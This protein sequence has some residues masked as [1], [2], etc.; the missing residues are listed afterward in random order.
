[1]L[2]LHGCKQKESL[3]ARERFDF[4]HHG[5]VIKSQISVCHQTPWGFFPA[6]RMGGLAVSAPGSGIPEGPAV[7]TFLMWLVVGRGG[8]EASLGVVFISLL[9]HCAQPIT[10][11]HLHLA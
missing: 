2:A 7:L 5:S 1:M 10:A 9:A 4:G 3:T 6:W 8:L 11:L